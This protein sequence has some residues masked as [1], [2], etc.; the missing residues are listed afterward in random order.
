MSVSRKRKRI[1]ILEDDNDVSALLEMA[2]QEAG[3]E[4]IVHKDAADV[5]TL[6]SAPPSVI[7]LDMV[8]PRAR[9]DGFSFLVGLAEQRA[10]LHIPL[11]ILSGLGDMLEKAL[12]RKM[13]ERLT[14]A[15]VFTKPFSLD[16]VLAKV[17]ELTRSA[18]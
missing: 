3:Y 13:V 14:I 5:D 2:L 15:G 4:P 11:I 18:A 1:L 17:N 6:A 10:A 8:M 9:M 16:E 12:D 7:I